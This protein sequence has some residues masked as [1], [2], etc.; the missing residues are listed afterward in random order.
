MRTTM[1]IK[2]PIHATHPAAISQTGH[3]GRGGEFPQG[4]SGWFHFAS[5]LP[6]SFNMV[7]SLHVAADSMRHVYGISIR[8]GI[9]I[10]SAPFT[11]VVTRI[12]D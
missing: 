3:H 4:M 12:M 11:S 7:D 2:K 10:F 9:S 1:A 5:T 6:L 8:T